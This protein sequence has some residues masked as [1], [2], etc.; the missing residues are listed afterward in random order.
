MPLTQGAVNIYIRHNVYNQSGN[1]HVQGSF[2]QLCTVLYLATSP[3]FGTFVL[4]LIYQISFW[5]ISSTTEDSSIQ[6]APLH[7]NTAEKNVP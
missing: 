1:F 2:F 6:N 4:C 3:K 5:G 7:L